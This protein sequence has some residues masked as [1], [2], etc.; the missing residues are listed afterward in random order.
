MTTLQPMSD[1]MEPTRATLHAY[2]HAV[3]AIPRVHAIPHPRWWH[4]SLNVNA[5]GFVTDTMSL[6]DGGVFQIRM[7]FRTHDI[8]VETNR[9][10]TAR[11]SMTD[12][13]TA[14][15]LGA[16][17]IEAVASLGLSGDYDS[18]KFDDDEPRPYD[19]EMAA[20]FF[21][22]IAD[23][24][25]VLQR[26]RATLSGE[27]GPIQ[28]WPHGFDLAFEW[29]GTRTVVHDEGGEAVSSP[30]QLN[31]G[32]YP[33]GRAYFYSNAWPY[34][35]EALSDTELPHGAAWQTEGWEGSI[36]YYD[37]VVGLPDGAE[38]VTD[39]AAAVYEA[40]APTLSA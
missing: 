3:G 24:H 29:F 36:L 16:D 5:T 32:F 18:S 38:R 7:D 1:D 14:K 22:V 4:I 39:Y 34:E 40:A 11:F 8:V 27:L 9:G 19:P 37:Q 31:L 23:A 10:E 30:A 28:L 13:I 33:A 20:A 21:V 15:Q 17:L 6:P 12:G 25:Q 26:H 35:A 2:A